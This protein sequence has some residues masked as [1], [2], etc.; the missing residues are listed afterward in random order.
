MHN[1]HIQL[2][3]AHQ[4]T[5]LELHLLDNTE[6]LELCSHLHTRACRQQQE[7]RNL[8]G[9]VDTLYHSLTEMQHRFGQL[10]ETL[11]AHCPALVAALGLH[12]PDEVDEAPAAD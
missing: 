4:R 12:A 10:V 1:N 8:Q 6:L 11:G 7:I 2:G 5:Y 9:A 3:H